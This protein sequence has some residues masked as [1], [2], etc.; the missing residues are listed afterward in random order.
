[1]TMTHPGLPEVWVYA[2]IAMMAVIA[3]W[4]MLARPPGQKDF[5]TFSLVKLPIL[6][7]IFRI[8]LTTPWLLFVLKLVMVALFLLIIIA[9][10]YGTPIPERNIATILTWNLWWAG[11]IFSIF[12]LGSAWCA[13]CPWDA[14]ALWMVRRRLWRRAEPNNSLNLRV[15][16]QL[17]SVWPALVIFIGFTW[18]ELGAGITVDPYAT[19]SIAL[20]MVVMATV[21][22]LVFQRKAFCRYFCPVGRTIGFYSQLSVVELRPIDSDKCANCKTLECYHGSEDVESCPTSLMMGSLQQNTYCTSCGNCSRSCP[23]ENVSW[24]LRS[25]SVEA[26]QSARPHW[27]EAC[28]M[29]TLLALTSFHGITMMPFWE[30]WISRLARLIGDSGQ[31]LWSFSVG[32]ALCI[33]G[34][35]LFYAGL[36]FITQKLSSSTL[37]FRKTFST[38]AF[39]A[40]PLAFAYHMAHNLNHLIREGA[41]LTDIFLNPLGI[42]TAPLTM[43]EKHMRHSDMLFSQTSLFVIQSVLMLAGFMIAIKVIRYRCRGIIDNENSTAGRIMLPMILFAA[44]MTI[45]HLWLMMQPMVMRM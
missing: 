30:E 44:G 38:L 2:I 8:L 10:L 11:L 45:A 25:P 17:R 33:L 14:M 12:F 24:R 5:A 13:I 4:A 26:V 36:V 22:M 20:L 3:A 15:P 29:I 21:S 18:L 23:D 32:I 9:G 34:V 1:M 35:V 6:G 28:F 42:D 7:S 27:D 39:V 37:S 41:G 43:M 31:L 16:R 40:L 19:A